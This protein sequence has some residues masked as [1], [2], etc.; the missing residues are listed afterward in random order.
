[1][2][3]HIYHRL[4]VV[5]DRKLDQDEAAFEQA[6]IR[7]VI[8]LRSAD[9]A[10]RI[11]PAGVTLISV[12]S[13]DSQPL[14]VADL[15][16]LLAAVDEGVQAGDGV[17]VYCPPDNRQALLLVM[18]Y[19][20]QYRGM[21]FANAY[22]FLADLFYLISFDPDWLF[23]LVQHCRLPYAKDQLRRRAFFFDLLSEASS[24]PS[25]ILHDLYVCSLAALG[26]LPATRALGIRAVLRLD[27]LEGR[28]DEQWP[29]DFTLLDVPINDGEPVA[30]D[31]LRRG[32]AFIDAQRRA[33]HK[34]LV[35]CVGG[36]SRS[37]TFTLAYLIEYQGMS[38]PEAYARIILRRAVARP[39]GELLASLVKHYHLPYSLDEARNDSFPD[40]LLRE[41]AERLPS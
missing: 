38:L 32:T 26:N 10:G 14:E 39:H 30:A 5:E 29:G 41:A 28:G 24:T 40:R 37:V 25:P 1:M 20:V 33:G 18:G 12:P 36:V 4:F 35:H 31:L 15:A 13:Q 3:R 9:L 7:R 6:G 19:L 27:D 11:W 23:V 17:A 2:L 8:T 34:V 22:V 21:T 16:H